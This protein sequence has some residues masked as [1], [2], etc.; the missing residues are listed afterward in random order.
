MSKTQT[1]LIGFAVGDAMGLPLEFMDRETLM[2]NP[3]TEM[4]QKEGLPLGM[5]SDDTAMTIATMDA[6][7]KDNGIDSKHI[8]DNFVDW[9][10]K[11]KYSATNK[12]YGIGKT[13]LQAITKYVNSKDFISPNRCGITDIKS[14]GNGSLMRMLPI[15]LYSYNK[16]LSDF[17]IAKLTNEISSLT[18]AHEIS[19]I[20]CYIYIKYI[21]FILDGLNPQ[22]AYKELQKSNYYFYKEENLSYFDRILKINIK[23]LTL[24]NLK[25]TG[26]VVDTLETVFWLILNTSSYSQTIIGAINLG[27]DT[28]TIAAI[29]GSISALIYG[30]DS[31]PSK[32][33]NKLMHKDELLHLAKAFDDSINTTLLT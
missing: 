10:V 17:E 31:I 24:D 30:Y 27:G 11:G 19:K 16:K 22:D 13:T 6:I 20:A 2:K 23:N 18:H 4:K 7:I 32:W 8:M 29:A 21:H 12:C 15:A 9:V 1:A 14:N 5:F 28:D 25:S 26:Y 3:A 33:K